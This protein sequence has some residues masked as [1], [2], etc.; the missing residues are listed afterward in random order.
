MMVGSFDRLLREADEAANVDE[1]LKLTLL[2]RIVVQGLVEKL[3]HKEAATSMEINMAT[4]DV[5][6]LRLSMP[7]I[8]K[9]SDSVTA[10][11]PSRMPSRVIENKKI[12]I[13]LKRH[14]AL[15]TQHSSDEDEQVIERKPKRQRKKSKKNVNQE[16]RVAADMPESFKNLI[17]EENGTDLLLVM[18]KKITNS[19]LNSDLNHLWIPRTNVRNDQFLN[20]VEKAILDSDKDTEVLMIPPSLK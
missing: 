2:T 3:S 5:D 17:R 18:Q 14:F 16:E 11:L 13:T 10:N 8:K 4:N 9:G 7:K 1:Y 15:T 19:D 12:K 20:Q 6:H